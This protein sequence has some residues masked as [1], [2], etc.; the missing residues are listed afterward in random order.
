MP[1]NP[2]I[3]R[4]L[5]DEPL[6]DVLLVLPELL[7]NILSNKSTLKNVYSFPFQKKKKLHAFKGINP[8]MFDLKK[9]KKE[10]AHLPP[11]LQTLWNLS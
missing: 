11:N 2:G 7:Q 8:G 1:L 6:K 3:E 5:W 10:K 4:Q 9:M